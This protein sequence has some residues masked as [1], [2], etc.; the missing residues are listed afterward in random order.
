MDD[1]GVHVDAQEVVE[2]VDCAV[3]V[4]RQVL[5]PNQSIGRSKHSITLHLEQEGVDQQ[6]SH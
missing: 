4:R 1:V 2:G 5:E 3:R 6:V